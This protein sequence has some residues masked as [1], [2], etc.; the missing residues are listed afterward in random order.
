MNTEYRNIMND[1][2]FFLFN[3]KK[4]NFIRNLLMMRAQGTPG[5]GSGLSRVGEV[6]LFCEKRDR[7]VSADLDIEIKERMKKGK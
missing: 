3:I 1:K 7:L 5:I 2:T 6:S 4:N